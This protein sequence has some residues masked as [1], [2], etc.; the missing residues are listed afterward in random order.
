[1]NGPPRRW[2]KR[3]RLGAQEYRQPGAICSVTIAVQS[4]RPVFAD[5]LI[6]QATEEILEERANATGVRV[7]AYCIMPDHI[8]IVLAPS[9]DCDIVT[10]VG[11]FKNLAQ[12]AV[13]R[14][15]VAGRF[16]QPSFWD[17]FLRGDEDLKRVAKYILAN[18]VRAGLVERWQ[19]YP[20]AG[21]LVW[22]VS[23]D[24]LQ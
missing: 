21:S 7:F 24:L 4:R 5:L 2:H 17:H 15:G 8:H 12:R 16:W 20:F 19:D 3:I 6:A 11:Q 1:M 13:W 22:D 14:H 10:F 18:P 9:V 23:T